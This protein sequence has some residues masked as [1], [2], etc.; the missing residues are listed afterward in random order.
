MIKTIL[1]TD[2]NILDNVVLR[3]Y[4]S[5][6]ERFNIISAINGREALDL[7]ESRNIDLILLDL[8]MPV[9][10]GYDF[11]KAFNKTGLHKLI[12][13]IVTSSIDDAKD[14]ER[15]LSYGIYDYI[16]KPLDH[17]NRQILLNKIKNA[18]QFRRNILELEKLKNQVNKLT[19]SE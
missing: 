8:I 17:I 5:S 1:V 13:I 10:D 4:L 14:I 2:D 11:L 7:V 15:V 6:K 16:I 12:P 3:D 9:M 18:I 19:A